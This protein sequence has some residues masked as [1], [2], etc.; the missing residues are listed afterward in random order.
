MIMVIL[1]VYIIYMLLLLLFFSTI[2]VFHVTHKYSIHSALLC[3]PF[4]FQFN[5]ICFLLN[6]SLFPNYS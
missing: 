3:K 4:T 5:A 6:V 1:N 2:T